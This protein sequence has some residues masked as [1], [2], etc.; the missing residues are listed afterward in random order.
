MTPPLTG[1]QVVAA[2]TAQLDYFQRMPQGDHVPAFNTCAGPVLLAGAWCNHWP[3][4]DADK[5]GY[6][7]ER[8]GT[9]VRL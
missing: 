3:M 2:A 9:A 1:A 4:R 8:C 7:C 6:T 5:L